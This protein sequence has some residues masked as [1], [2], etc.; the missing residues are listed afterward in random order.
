[1]GKGKCDIN[2]T[3]SVTSV[4]ANTSADSKRTVALTKRRDEKSEGWEDE[5]GE[6]EA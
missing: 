5:E 2:M 3:D 1:M 4:C 6:R